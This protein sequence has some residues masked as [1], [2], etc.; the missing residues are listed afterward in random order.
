MH[1]YQRPDATHVE[2]DPAATS[3]SGWAARLNLA[4]QKGN[5]LVLANVG[6]ISPGFNPNDTGFQYGASDIINMQIIPGYQWT[7]PGKV[8]LSALV[9]G[10]W[11][12]NY[13]FGGNKNWDGGLVEFQG[14][15]RNFW[16]FDTMFAYNP[17][18]VSKNLTRGGPLA[19]VP[20]GYQFNLMLSTDSRKPVV[21]EFQGTTY[22]RP[23]AASEWQGELSVRWKPGS[24]FSLSVGP[25]LGFER[26]DIQWVRAVND[27]LMTETYGRRYVFGRIDQTV[28]GSE[29]RLDWTF[30]PKLTLQAYLQPFLAVGRYD[31]FKELARSK[32]FAYNVYGGG[33]WGDVPAGGGGGA[34]GS[35]ISYDELSGAY[36]VDPDGAAGAAAPFSFGNPDFNYKSLRGTVVLR[37]EY[38]PGSLLYFVWTQNRADYANP[39]DLRIGRDLGDLFSAPGDNIFLLK[40]SYR[41]NM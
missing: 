15:F 30:T 40:V 26:N 20:S 7:K 6:A 21:F 5:L 34:N 29:I 41:W 19:V 18:T 14:Q 33:A 10:G 32:S 13:D 23:R 25:T 4:K 31:M 39:G 24:N 36:T 35:T 37:W 8:F 1:Y 9:I 11:F 3:L 22:Q 38:R 28:I 12:R 2:L 16:M 27:A 17:D